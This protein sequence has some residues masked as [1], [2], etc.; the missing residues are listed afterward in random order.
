VLPHGPGLAAIV[1]SSAEDLKL[2]SDAELVAKGYY[3]DLT[4]DDRQGVDFLDA[5]ET[6]GGFPRDEG[7]P[8]DVAVYLASTEGD[9]DVSLPVTIGSWE[10]GEV[11]VPEG[12]MVIDAWNAV[13]FDGGVPGGMFETSLADGFVGN[14]LEVVSRISEWLF[15][16]VDHLPYVYGGGPFPTD[17]AYVLRGAG[18]GNPLITDG[19]AWVLV[20]PIPPAPLYTEAGED[21]EDQ[22]IAEG[23]CPPLMNWLANEIGVP[24]EDIQVVVANTLALNTDIQPCEMCARLLDASKTLQD[25]EGTRIAALTQVINQFVTTPAPPSPEQMTQIAV[26][27][28]EHVGDGTYYALAGEWIDAVVAY[29]NIMNTE[30]GYSA[31]DSVAFAEKY[32]TPVTDVGNVTLTAYVTARLA[33]LGG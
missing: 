7:D 30:M 4:V 16:A 6:I 14:R 5:E 10:Q 28:S 17:Y 31:A 9:V 12:T 23:G 32:L 15:E 27:F 26:A 25:A 33:A 21:A 20:D 22:D 11:F 2:G 24:A 3:D 13:T 8:F 29:V 18:L 19:R 1:F